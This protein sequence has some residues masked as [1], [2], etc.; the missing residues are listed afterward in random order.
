MRGIIWRMTFEDSSS[1]HDP[2][3]VFNMITGSSVASSLIFRLGRTQV[4]KMSRIWLT[5]VAWSGDRYW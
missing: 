5:L 1:S 2:H 4:E 3:L